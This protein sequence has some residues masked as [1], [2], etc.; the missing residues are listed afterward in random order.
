M[1]IVGGLGLAAAGVGRHAVGFVKEHDVQVA[2]EIQL[3]AA[4][5]AH[6]HDRQQS[7][8]SPATGPS[9]I[10]GTASLAVSFSYSARAMRSEAHFG[11][12]RQAPTSVD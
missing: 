4:E 11:D 7:H 5:L 1:L 10:V 2:V 9:P 6:A 3:P 8:G 12:I